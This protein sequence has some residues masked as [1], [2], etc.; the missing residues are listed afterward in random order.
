MSIPSV[1][2][3]TCPVCQAPLDH[4]VVAVCSVCATAHH[5][6]CWQRNERCATEGCP[7]TPVPMPNAAVMPQP[8]TVPAGSMSIPPTPL[9]PY[10]GAVPGMQMIVPQEIYVEGTKIL[11]VRNHCTLPPICIATGKMENLIKR[12]RTESWAP[13]WIYWLLLIGWLIVLIVYYCIRKTVK[14]DVFLDKN[15]AARRLYLMIGN[16]VLFLFLFIGSFFAFSN[17]STAGLGACMIITSIIGPLIVYYGFIRMYTVVKIQ[18]DY[19]WLKF[20]DPDIVSAI[21]AASLSQGLR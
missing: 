5:A 3:T 21:Y 4:P 2:N 20:R 13:S 9:P 18:N 7:G 19:A 15:Y 8:I 1:Q 17:E 12:K 14:F 6:Q 10:S 11:I 16:W